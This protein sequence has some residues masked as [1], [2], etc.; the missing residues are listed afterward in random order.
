MFENSSSHGGKG[1]GNARLQ[2]AEGGLLRLDEIETTETGWLW[3]GRIPLGHVTVVAGEAASGKSLLAAEIAAR[4]SSGE[5]W[6][7]EAALDETAPDETAPDETALA[8]RSPGTVVIAQSDRH[9]HAVVK[10]RLVAAGADPRQVAIVQRTAEPAEDLTPADE[11]LRQLESALDQVANCSL[12]IVDHL[13]GWLRKANPR[14]DERAEVF[15]RLAEL[16]ARR[17]I[18]LV[19]VWRLEKT[20]PGGPARALD[21]LSAVAPVVWMLARDPYRRDSHRAVCAQNQLGRLANNLAF[22]VEGDRLVWQSAA[23]QATAD[24]FVAA[25]GRSV[26]RYERRQAGEW[27]LNLLS[28]G[29]I[30]A[31]RLWEEARQCRLSERTVRRAASDL[32]L[33]LIKAGQRGPWLWGFRGEAVSDNPTRDDASSVDASEPRK[34]DVEITPDDGTDS[35]GVHDACAAAPENV[36]ALGTVGSL[37]DSAVLAVELRRGESPS[38]ASTC[39]DSASPNVAA[40]ETDGSLGTSEATQADAKAEKRRLRKLRREKRRSENET[41]LEF[42]NLLRNG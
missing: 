16:A 5:A 42:H 15:D 1:D 29:P 40:L 23:G 39:A 7:D 24:E 33:H 18:A 35:V 38:V 27:L 22:R 19:V 32:D 11:L 20:A 34:E 10:R 36:A 8:E 17:R 41:L 25:T 31:G 21:A 4:S 37:P 28:E 26:D 30:E 12:V 9:L 2:N 3:P 14:A 6:P 13:T